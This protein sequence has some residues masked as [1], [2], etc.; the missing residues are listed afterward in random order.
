V[1]IQE[2]NVFSPVVPN[3]SVIKKNRSPQWNEKFE[4][5]IR[6]LDIV[7]HFFLYDWELCGSNRKIGAGTLSLLEIL[8]HTKYEEKNYQLHFSS[9]DTV[10]KL[11]T[12]SEASALRIAAFEI[13]IEMPGDLF[14]TLRQD[15]EK[16]G[17]PRLTVH[18]GVELQEIGELMFQH[19][20]LE[21]KIESL[22][23]KEQQ[24]FVW[25]S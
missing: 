23:S 16:H 3:T 15:L 19:R 14:R 13:P 11:P 8:N 21:Y 20:N 22:K 10:K 2:K 17:N 25:R 4:F 1:K 5:C 24:F 6:T 7:L 12:I 18:C 9:R